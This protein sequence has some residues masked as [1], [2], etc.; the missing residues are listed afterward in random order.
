[1]RKFSFLTLLTSLLIVGCTEVTIEQSNPL[2]EINSLPDLTASFADEGETRTFVEDS[3]YLRWHE[4]DLITAFFGNT[5][6]RQYKFKGKTGDNSGT[7]SLVPSGE[8]GT[9]NDLSSIYAVYPYDENTTITD[10]GVISLT[11]PATQTYAENSFGKG[12]NTMVAVTESVE[13]TF[14]SFK[15]A[16]GYLKLKLY[17]DDVTIA[18]IEVKGNNEEKIAGSATATME[19]GGVPTIAMNDEATTSVTLDC[20]EG[21]S[22]GATADMATEFWIVL[23]ETTFESGITITATN[24]DGAV[25]S[26]ST[27]NT[28]AITRN[29]IQPMVALK[30]EFATAKPANNEIW[31]TSS[32]ASVVTPNNTAAFGANIVSNT[33]K[34]D[35]GVLTFD[36]DVDRIHN[37]AFSGCKTLSTIILPDGVEFVGYEAFYMCEALTSITIP[38]SLYDIWYDAFA[39]CN[40]L[41]DVFIS[42]LTAWCNISFQEF[43]SNPLCYGGNLI[44]NGVLIKDLIVP[45]DITVIEPYAFCGCDSLISVTIPDNVNVIGYSSFESCNNL[46]TIDFSSNVSSIGRDAFKYCYGISDVYCRPMNCPALYYDEY[47]GDW[48]LHFYSNCSIY[49]PNLSIGLY[50]TADGWSKYVDR[51]VAYDFEKGEIVPDTTATPANNEIWYTNGSTTEPTAPAVSTAFG[52]AK[53]VSNTY[54]TKKECWVI[55]F[56]TDVTTIGEP[57]FIDCITLTSV[58][59]PDSVTSIGNGAFC[60][61]NN[62]TTVIIPESVSSIGI[63]SFGECKSLIDINLPNNITSIG[64]GAFNSCSN[65]VEIVLPASTTAIGSDLFTGC[66]SLS[67]VA[68]PD[69]LISIGV[70]AFSNCTSLKNITIPD[71]VKTIGNEAFRSCSQLS[72]ISIPSS[73]TVIGDSIFAECTSLTDATISDSVSSM[74]SYVFGGCSSLI[75]VTLPNSLSS[76]ASQTFHSCSSLANITIPDS[77]TTIESAAF[78]NCIALSSI[79]IPDCVK[80]IGNSAFSYCSRLKYIKIPSCLEYIE[81]DT[82]RGCESLT[83]INIPDSV[84]GIDSFAFYGC[85]NLTDVSL[86]NNITHIGEQAFAECAISS[87]TIPNSVYTIGAGVFVGCANLESFYGKFAS[88]DNRCLIDDYGGLLYAF[89][90]NRITSYIIPDNVKTITG[91]AFASCDVDEILIPSSVTYIDMNAFLSSSLTKLYCKSDVPPRIFDDGFMDIGIPYNTSI[92]VPYN[93]L[94][95]YSIS[96]SRYSDQLN[97]YY[98]DDEFGDMEI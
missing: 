82:F 26:K 42:D 12:A 61:C 57:A 13:D 97:G 18:S 33:Y 19:F 68:L 87:I 14:L 8:L 77:V 80:T 91:L 4:S 45:T 34:N 3:K 9:G 56:D 59:I 39:Y 7:F 96:W 73:V 63:S 21:V 90:P 29:D 40:N 47:Y 62:L 27:T 28:V 92:Y 67:N 20:G 95:D 44:L 53:I 86:G 37:E 49:V 38:Q 11:L 32:D 30:A 16:C 51:L 88:A 35:R 69:N 10:N 66:T 46:K 48:G 17:G 75:N 60:R 89:A 58:I 72:T 6:N 5:L 65:L 84:F 24:T 83:S 93:S 31:Y 54:D 81:S 71:S 64:D 74:G 1:M 50:R 36:S 41:K 43:C 23:P 85:V 70:R 94:D 15:N 98:F 52:S 76:I 2:T 22:I 79:T 25:F 55:K 78:D